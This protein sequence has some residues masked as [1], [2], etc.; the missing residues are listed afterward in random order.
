MVVDDEAIV[1]RTIRR[2]LAGHHDATVVTSGEEALRELAG[3]ERYDVIL[4][5]LMM[6]GM[7]GM[8]VYEELS[9]SA[10]D[11]ARRMV[12][13]TGGAFTAVAREFLDSIPNPRVEKPFD[14][15]SLLAIIAIVGR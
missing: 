13:V 12:F 11:Q 3:G 7:S 4:C 2:S 14:V 15:Q 8:Q 1:G 9:T 10:A 6:P 5:D